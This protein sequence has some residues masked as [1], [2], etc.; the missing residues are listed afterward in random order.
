MEDLSGGFIVR[1]SRY[2]AEMSSRPVS[3]TPATEPTAGPRFV[4]GG[5]L[6]VTLTAHWLTG[7]WDQEAN[8]LFGAPRVTLSVG[9]ELQSSVSK[10]LRLL[11][12]G[13]GGSARDE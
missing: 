1:M 9:D 12:F 7:T 8:G 2:L 13:R 11:D 4:V 5:S 10:T 3:A 6:P